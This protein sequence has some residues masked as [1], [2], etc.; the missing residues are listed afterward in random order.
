[1]FP[2]DTSLWNYSNQIFTKVGRV[3]GQCEGRFGW[4]EGVSIW[5]GNVAWLGGVMGHCEG[6][7][8]SLKG[9]AA[10]M[11]NFACSDGIW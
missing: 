11:V 1:M 7:F 9:F 3:M 4:F 10:R 5:M 6:G 2:K 8:W